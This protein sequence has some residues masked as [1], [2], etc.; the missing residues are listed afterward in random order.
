MQLKR[1]DHGG[2]VGLDVGRHQV[3]KVARLGHPITPSKRTTQRTSAFRPSLTP[4]SGHLE[5]DVAGF[6]V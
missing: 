1:G 3:G 5:I 2:E 4:G 6:V